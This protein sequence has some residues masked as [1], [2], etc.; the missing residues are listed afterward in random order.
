MLGR[1][2]VTL[3]GLVVV[4]LFVALFAPFFVDW[5]SF[6]QEFE[7]RSSR[8]LG[9]K[10]TVH[11][12]VSARL[13]PFPSLSMQDVTIGADVDGSP[14]VT[15]ERFSLDAELAPLLS[16]EARIFDMRIEEP[17]ARIR[18]LENGE[19]DWLRGSKPSLPARTVVLENL[20]ITGGAVEFIDQQSGRNRLITDLDAKVSARTLAGPWSIEGHAVLDGEPGQFTLQSA[21]PT[22]GSLPLRVHLA[23]EMR[24]VDINMDGALT[25]RDGR[26]VYQGRFDA[27]VKAG[28]SEEQGNE[29]QT[30][31]PRIRGELEVTNDSIAI[32]NY[33]LEVGDVADP[34]V[35]TGTGKLDTGARPEFNLTAEGQQIDVAKLEAQGSAGKT[36]RVGAV[37][38][39]HRLDVVLRLAT[40]IP[41]PNVPGKASLRLPAIVAGDTVFREIQFDVRPDAS[42]W[43]IEKAVAV[44][45]GKTH[46]EASG[47]LILGGS[48]S[49][50]GDLLVASTQPSGL[51]TWLSGDV[52]PAIR[53][54]RS[55]GLSASVNLT[56][57]LQ[58]F[59]KLELALGSDPL[60]GRMERDSSNNG[61]TSLSIDLAGDVLNL[62]AARA[63]TALVA[64]RDEADKVSAEKV[65]AR[66]QLQTLVAMG[67]EAKQVDAILRYSGGRLEVERLNIG[68]LAGTTL[69]MTGSMA[70]KAE[71]PEIKGRMTISTADP[72]GLLGLANERYPTLPGL[73]QSFRAARFYSDTDLTLD[74]ALSDAGALTVSGEGRSNGSQLRLSYAGSLKT[75][76]DHAV[77]VELRNDEA[78]ILMGQIGMD[79]LPFPVG[80]GGTV[81]LKITTTDK[82]GAD[83][84]ASYQAQKTRLELNGQTTDLSAGLLADGAW[85]LAIDSADLAPYLVAL[86]TNLPDLQVGLPAKGA[87]AFKVSKKT[88]STEDFTAEIVGQPVK[89][90]VA[91]DLNDTRP[92][93]QGGVSTEQ[94]D[95]AWLAE[96]VTGPL[97][98]PQSGLLAQAP[99][100]PGTL[101]FDVNLK[102][103]ADRLW[104]GAVEAVQQF[105]GNFTLSEREAVIQV[106]G[107][108]WLGGAASGRLAIANADGAGLLQGKLTV[109]GADV[110]RTLDGLRT[111]RGLER[112]GQLAGRANLD[113][114]VEGTGET[115][116]S[117]FG[118]VTGSGQ[119]VFDR[120]Q[121]TGLKLGIMPELIASGDAI[122]TAIDQEAVRGIIGQ[123]ITADSA[124]LDG[125][126]LQLSLADK[127]LRVQNAVFNAEMAALSGD[128]RLD[129][130]SGEVDGLVKIVL[131]AGDAAIDGT[132]A[133]FGLAITGPFVAP[134]ISYDVTELTN[135]L[136]L[137]AFEAERRRVEALQSSVLE[138][139]RLRRESALARARQ[140]ERARQDAERAK[141]EEQTRKDAEAA[142]AA[143]AAEESARSVPENI[144]DPGTASPDQ[145]EPVLPPPQPA[146]ET[147]IP[148]RTGSTMPERRLSVSPGERVVRQPLPDVRFNGL[149]GVQ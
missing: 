78:G 83:L 93:L 71:S 86:K 37:S 6:R 89:G 115:A 138:K 103:A 50:E 8:I 1:I 25:L 68:D 79:P 94:L 32:P 149:P 38:L 33:R 134:T 63:I 54:L 76:G 128:M 135:F 109:K 101:P 4:A 75:P 124:K 125:L 58:R 146:Q 102:L 81:G 116:A 44:L 13:L 40:A 74:V 143:R 136:A 96:T 141:Q 126:T 39:K 97:R 10:V 133:A 140:E 12:A 88:V 148:Q 46:V 31:A 15:I 47:K 67:V 16:G 90:R 120:L 64:G 144:S 145:A 56:Q 23:P 48:P 131:N 118:G 114:V 41:I 77:D 92:R 43:A 87:V 65:A 49:F 22:A 20:T 98:D 85:S 100:S 35:V 132:V 84:S 14:L 123:T 129:L 34:Y 24:P 19:L 11:G 30:P 108:S 137:R 142:A 36:S 17:R 2:L 28:M 82:G 42:G 139:Q 72:A 45:P 55:A 3:G 117:L 60:K 119:L 52:D 107:G 91:F 112:G 61:E 53:Q 113:L 70:G 104:V 127:M 21:P 18:L 106:D 59:E 121:V 95:L 99:L 57:N 29:E 80:D 7:D 9:K 122:G 51:A 26:P 130:Q 5:T 111:E 110:G 27:M 105:S 147:A 66:L 62:D 73:A 69:R